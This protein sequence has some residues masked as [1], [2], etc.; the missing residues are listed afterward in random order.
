M[1]DETANKYSLVTESLQVLKDRQRQKELQK[2]R[3]GNPLMHGHTIESAHLSSRDGLDLFAADAKAS[4]ST[5]SGSAGARRDVSGLTKKQRRKQRRI[6]KRK[7]AK[8]AKKLQRKTGDTTVESEEASEVPQ[9]KKPK[10][11]SKKAQSAKPKSTAVPSPAAKQSGKEADVVLEPSAS[12]A[13]AEP[14]NRSRRKR[15]RKEAASAASE[16]VRPS[17]QPV[18][19]VEYAQHVNRT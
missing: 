12:V 7:I 1:C 11:S 18:S 5:A 6:E 15:A 17:P 4:S 14:N 19:F 8:E 3:E 2:E 9:S 10:K 16:E 13:S